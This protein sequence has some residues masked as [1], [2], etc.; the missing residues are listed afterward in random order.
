[1][2]TFAYHA[3]AAAAAANLTKY[4]ELTTADPDKAQQ[5]TG[6][7]SHHTPQLVR[8]GTLGNPS[9][10]QQF[11]CMF[12]GEPTIISQPTIASDDTNTPI[13]LAGLGESIEH[14]VPVCLI[15]AY[16]TGYFVTLIAADEVEKYQLPEMQVG[17]NRP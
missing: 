11:L 10:A 8:M 2:P 6:T 14:H 15:A 16:L 17:P 12:Q 13:Y 1:M 9:I 5:I 7:L 3:T 4:S